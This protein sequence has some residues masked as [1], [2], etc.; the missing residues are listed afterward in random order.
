M[1]RQMTQ[2][3]LADDTGVNVLQIKGDEAAEAEPSMQARYRPTE[4]PHV[5]ANEL[6]QQG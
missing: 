4:A 2:Q 3:T 6:V 5:G 1:D